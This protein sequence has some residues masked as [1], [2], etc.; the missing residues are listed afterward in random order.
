MTGAR[1]P[2]DQDELFTK[3]RKDYAKDNLSKFNN[4]F[5]ESSYDNSFRN[6]GGKFGGGQQSQPHQQSQPNRVDRCVQNFSRL[7]NS[8]RETLISK[9]SSV[10]K[11]EGDTYNIFLANADTDATSNVIV[12]SSSK[13]NIIGSSLVSVLNE[14]L[15]ANGSSL[16][17][18]PCNKPFRFGGGRR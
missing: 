8:E 2:T 17:T 5:R 11:V 14:N 15:Q 10:L 6:Q 4:K 12:D 3:Y 1:S 18:R 16:V 13:F 9:L 7:S